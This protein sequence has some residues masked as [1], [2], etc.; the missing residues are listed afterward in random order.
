MRTLTQLSTFALVLA[1]AGCASYSPGP[2]WTDHLAGVTEPDQL[3][4]YAAEQCV[5]SVVKDVCYGGVT[6][7]PIGVC[8]D[9]VLGGRCI[10]IEVHN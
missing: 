7:G 1:I 10:G 9:A 5:G 4:M 6:G 2:K 3:M 8:H